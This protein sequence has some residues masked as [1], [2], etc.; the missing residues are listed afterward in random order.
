MEYVRSLLI[1]AGQR[2]LNKHGLLS[3]PFDLVERSVLPSLPSISR[4][5]LG[6]FPGSTRAPPAIA[7]HS[8]ASLILLVLCSPSTQ[9]LVSTTWIASI[10]KWVYLLC[11]TFLGQAFSWVLMLQMRARFLIEQHCLHDL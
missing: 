7:L 11:F 4:A 2:S 9:M 10:E 6:H 5:L 8:G 1:P 3:A